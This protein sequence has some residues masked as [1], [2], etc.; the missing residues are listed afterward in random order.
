MRIKLNFFLMCLLIILNNQNLFSFDTSAENA[1]L[2]DFDTNQILYSKNEEKKIYPAS[3]SK[4]M[5][6]YILFDSLKKGI[7]TLDDKFVVSR[8]AYQK[9]GSTIYAELGTEISV[10]NLI[11]GIIVS[12]GNDACIIVAEALSGS[13]DNFANQMNFYAEEMGLRNSNFKNSSGLHNED[14]YTSAEDLVKLSN[15]LITDFPDYYPYFAERS[16]TWNSIIQYNR[17]NIL[18]MDLG[19]DGLKTGYTSKSGY[20]VIVSSQKNGRR[21]IGIVTGLK[22]VDDRTNEISRLINYGYRG[23]KSYSV[24]KDNQIIDY[25]KVWKGNKNNLPL[26][27]DKDINLLLDI[28]GRRGINVE[29]KYNEPIYAPIFKGDVVGSIDI[30]IPGRKNIKLDLLAG[31][32]VKQVNFFTGFIRS[33]DYFLYKDE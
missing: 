23:F 33:L 15:L 10:Q 4:L 11:R 31:E 2:I 32:D 21:L 14:H 6:L 17:N 29:Y 16:F 22:S 19:V 25:A 1:L 18:R 27:V 9:E 3:M 13:E 24:F 26:I 12:S 8:N 20:G 5:T 28:P 30:I 7:V